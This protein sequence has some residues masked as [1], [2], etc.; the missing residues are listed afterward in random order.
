MK[1]KDKIVML[2]MCFVLAAGFGINYKYNHD[3]QTGLL[4]YGS[5]FVGAITVLVASLLVG[6]E[7]SE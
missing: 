4:F 1:R 2:T 7:G 6:E 5:A 3:F